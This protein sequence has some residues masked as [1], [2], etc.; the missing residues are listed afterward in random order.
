MT[1]RTRKRSPVEE[2]LDDVESY[3]EEL[4]QSKL[5]FAYHGRV[6]WTPPTDVYETEEEFHVV[7]A[8]PGSKK[9][10]L[11]VEFE[12]DTLRVRG[13]RH[14]PAGEKRHY[15][16]MEIPVGPF[17]RRVRLGRGIR[18]DE[19]RVRYEEGLLRISLP[20]ARPGS[21]EVPID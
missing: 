16:K 9:D 7:M 3:V 14:E 21:V 10:E 18:S 1:D 15:Y 17:E 4:F 2:L 20:K 8:V 5:P 11:K 19:I 12:R 13:M 6:R